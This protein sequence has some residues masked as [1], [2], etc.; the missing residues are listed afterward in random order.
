[1]RRALLL[2]P[3]LLFAVHATAQTA[4][5][6]PQDEPKALY[7]TIAALDAKLFDAYNRCDLETFAS[8]F[9]EK[10]E[11]YDDQGGLDTDRAEVI[12][13]LRK[14]ICGKATRELVAGTLEVYPM[15]DFGAV[16]I[17]VHRFHHPGHDDTEPLG[18]AKFVHLWQYK[19]GTWKLTRVISFDHHAVPR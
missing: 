14:Y 17:G 11:F 4:Q 15:K 9:P 3:L 16:E 13:A 5:T 18:E 1:M 2:L 6:A 12:A 10:F 7:T 19:N 8:F